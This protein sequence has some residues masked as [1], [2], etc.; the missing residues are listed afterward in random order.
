MG[1]RRAEAVLDRL[2][3]GSGLTAAALREELPELAGTVHL[4]KGKWAAE[5]SL[6]PRVLTLLGAEGLIVRGRNDG[7]W[8]ISR[9]LWTAM[10]DWLGESPA[11]APEAEGYA[12]LVTAWLRS[13]GPGTEADLVW[14]LGATKGA[15]RRA[16]ADAGAV[17]V[18]LDRGQTGWVLADDLDPVGPVA[19]W[20]ALLPVLD[21]TTMG[22]KQRDFYLA[23]DHAPYLFDAN[24]NAGATAWWDGRVVGCW[25]QDEDGVVRV[26]VREDVGAEAG[27]ALD[28]EARRLSAFLDGVRIN[29]VYASPEMRAALRH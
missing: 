16:L 5:V 9:P 6:A 14:W 29:S 13:F 27:A 10:S 15:V 23:P 7:H 24:G 12:A 28:V 4:G 25:V 19:P 3:D 20:A 8:R 11:P 2:S 17:E 21:P 22:W 1:G 18:S 26:V